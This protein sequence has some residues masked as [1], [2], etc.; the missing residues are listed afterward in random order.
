MQAAPSSVQELWHTLSPGNI[1]LA[2]LVIGGTALTVRL[3][4]R[5]IQFL[6]SKTARARV[7]LGWAS[8]VVRIGLWFIALLTVVTLLA[9]SREGFLAALASAGLAVGLGAQDLVKN[10]LGGLVILADRPYQLGDR[11]QIGGAYGEIVQIGL[12]STK[13]V[14]PDDS[15]V[16]IPNSVVVNQ[17]VSNSNAGALDCQVVTDLYLPVTVD[18]DFALRVGYEAAW[19]C[20]YV[21][22]KKPIVVLL[23]EHFDQAPYVRLRIKA[24][25]FDHRLERT[26]QSDITRR[27]KK[28]FLEAGVYE[29][30]QHLLAKDKSNGIAV[31]S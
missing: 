4:T 15:L 7:I 30:W 18:P 9:P 5:L 8:P 6:A 17:E 28:V 23:T 19:S 10:T 22:L 25:V 1:L 3:L 21:Y 13:L 16:T 2:L 20:P 12:R 24:Y 31:G 27:A 14:T 26:L 11:V 29:G